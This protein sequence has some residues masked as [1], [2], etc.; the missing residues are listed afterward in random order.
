MPGAVGISNTGIF[1][2]AE[3]KYLTRLFIGVVDDSK[4]N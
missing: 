2:A 3:Y 4:K 1:A